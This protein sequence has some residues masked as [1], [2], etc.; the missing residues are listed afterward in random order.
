MLVRRRRGS[1]E[2]AVN[3]ATAPPAREVQLRQENIQLVTTE[4]SCSCGGDGR[5]RPPKPFQVTDHGRHQFPLPHSDGPASSLHMSMF[6]FFFGHPCQPH[7]SFIVAL[8]LG[9]EG[10][11][12]V[13]SS[14]LLHFGSA[15]RELE[16][17]LT[18]PSHHYQ[19]AAQAVSEHRQ[20][21]VLW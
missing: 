16:T 17:G 8:Q 18:S 21:F 10:V 5:T 15:G 1:R 6:L 12:S 20:W 2:Q 7:S 9:I 3:F 13:R 11:S 4:R 14:T 19:S